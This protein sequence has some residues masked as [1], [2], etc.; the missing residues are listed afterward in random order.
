MIEKK[1]VPYEYLL[2]TPDGTVNFLQ[3]QDESHSKVRKKKVSRHIQNV[4]TSSSSMWLSIARVGGPQQYWILFEVKNV[5]SEEK[6][7]EPKR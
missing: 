5:V 4:Q 2:Q 6:K 1:V 3:G 7:P